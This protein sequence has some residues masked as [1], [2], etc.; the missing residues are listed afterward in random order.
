MRSS[1][2]FTPSTATSITTQF[3]DNPDNNTLEAE[4]YYKIQFTL[5]GNNDNKISAYFL[6][7]KGILVEDN[8]YEIIEEDEAGN[9][10]TYAIYVPKQNDNKIIY[11]YQTN[12]SSASLQTNQSIS[13]ES[14]EAYIS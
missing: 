3:L 5:D 9:Y 2:A 12:S 13:A 6:K 11:S 10:R 8:Y 14:P 4:K 1:P 7:N